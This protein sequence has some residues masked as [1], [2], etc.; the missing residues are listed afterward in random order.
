MIN[1]SKSRTKKIESFIIIFDKISKNFINPN[2]N[3]HINI[4]NNKNN[5]LNYTLVEIHIAL[6]FVP[7]S[8]LTILF[9]PPDRLINMFSSFL[10]SNPYINVRGSFTYTG[11]IKP[12]TKS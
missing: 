9:Y 4:Y 3:F 11:P 5:L 2:N 12:F 10:Y 7:L 1:R 8:I 6:I